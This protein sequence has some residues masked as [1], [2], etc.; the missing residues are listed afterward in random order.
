M[1]ERR[2]QTDGERK[3]GRR[4][5][6]AAMVVDGAGIAAAPGVVLLE[7]RRIVAAGA[8]QSV[9]MP[10]DALVVDHLDAV[11]M[12]ALVNAHC[13]LD[14][15][16]IGPVG[17]EGGFARWL[18][19]V[20]DR[21]ATTDDAIAA[22]VGRG[23]EMITAGGTA[24]VG[25][26]A[27]AGS[28]VPLEVL[29]RAP[30]AGVSYVEVFGHGRRQGG[31]IAA[32]RRTV[33]LDGGEAGGV[34]LG[35][36]PHAPYSCGPE[37]YRE[38]AALG[39]PLATHLAETVDEIRFVAEREGPFVD[40]LKGLGAWDETIEA[41][42]RH[43]VEAVAEWIDAASCLAAHVNYVEAAHL[44]LLAA[45]GFRVV[46]CPRASRYF[47]HPVPGRTGHRYRSMLEMGIDVALG[48]DSVLC[49]DTPDRMSVLDEMR[50]LHG[51]DGTDPR[52]LLR[53]ATVNGAS[54]LGVDPTF[55]TLAPG[56]V[57]G[58]LLARIDPDRDV[59]PLRQSLDNQDAPHW[60]LPPA[61]ASH[62]TYPDADP[63]AP[64]V[65]GLRR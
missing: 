62:G 36:Q 31:A 42:H 9:G 10:A 33:A 7:G 55:V 63:D 26:I 49:L 56:P 39:V 21:R 22:S 15:S 47:G 18:E 41:H 30:L 13:H 17:F 25:D 29:R 57:A 1:P 24:L 4:L 51:R 19:N 16:H 53:M 2:G 3:N 54:A 38:A 20:R 12:P 23:I 48:T 50:L 8:P 6:R 58:L 44:P 52:L 5:V 28:P 65:H 27:G 34:R 32:M 14:L 46:Y 40:L 60:L 35:L 64:T 61:F 45:R 37:V 59:D 11:V 43:P